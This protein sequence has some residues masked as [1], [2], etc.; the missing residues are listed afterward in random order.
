MKNK[1]LTFLICGI[2]LSLFIS[3]GYC[4][5]FYKSVDKNG[6]VYITNMPTDTSRS[7]QWVPVYKDQTPRETNTVTTAHEQGVGVLNK[8][9]VPASQYNAGRNAV[10]I[11]SAQHPNVAFPATQY[12]NAAYLSNTNRPPDNHNRDVHVKTN[13]DT[14]KYNQLNQQVQSLN[15]QNAEINK[16]NEAE[17]IRIGAE[18]NKIEAKNKEIDK[19]NAQHK[20]EADAVRVNEIQERRKNLERQAHTG[21]PYTGQ[22]GYRLPERANNRVEPQFPQPQT[23]IWDNPAPQSSW[24]PA[25]RSLR[26]QVSNQPTGLNKKR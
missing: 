1:F 22:P 12:P 19:V 2:A 10:P 6:N 25:G 15:N 9:V 4:G 20:K 3:E 8:N 16:R 11:L 13:N 18:N 23:N 7:Y 21:Q 14:T 5:E 17:R 26:P 24:E